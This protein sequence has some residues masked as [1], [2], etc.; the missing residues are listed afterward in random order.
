[1]KMKKMITIPLMLAILLSLLSWSALAPAAAAAGPGGVKDF[2]AVWV[3]TVVNLDYPSKS[4]LT[5][6]QLRSEADKILDAAKDLNMTAV[7]LQVRPT[8]DAI[9]PS[10]IFPWSRFLSGSQ[11]VAPPENFDALKYYIDGAHARGMELHAWINPYRISMGSSGAPEHNTNG[12]A[13][14]NPARQHPEWVI[15]HTD[16]RMYYD[17]GIPE[18]RQLVIDGVMEI[19]ENY[20]VDGIHFDDYFYPGKVADSAAFARYPRGFKDIETWRRDNVDLLVKELSDKIKQAAPGVRFGI[21]PAGIWANKS[22]SA[23]GSDTRGNESYVA[24]YADTRKW[25]KLGWLDYIAP[26][27]YWNIGYSIADYAKLVPWWADV[28]K[29]T[30][31]DLYIGLPDYRVDPA[32]SSSSVWK[33]AD[34]IIRQIEFNMK[35]A[36]VTGEIHFR[37]GSLT[38]NTAL[39]SAVKAAY[40]DGKPSD[41]VFTS[42]GG[43]GGN[44]SANAINW[45]T[46]A[47]AAVEPFRTVAFRRP[48]GSITTS[49]DKYYVMGVSDPSL[50]LKI[51]GEEVANR[52]AAGF[53]AK[54]VTLKSG[55][56]TVTAT[57]GNNVT[58]ITITRSSGTSS[59]PKPVD[60][61]TLASM[62]PSA[63]QYRQSGDAMPVSCV[64]PIGATVTATLGGQTITLKAAATSKPDSK[65]YNTTFSGSFKL[66]AAGAG[67]INKLGRVSYKMTYSGKTV[68]GQSGA[69]TSVIGSGARVYIEVTSGSTWFYD[70]N[71]STGGPSGELYRGMKDYVVTTTGN[72]IKLSMGKWVYDDNVRLYTTDNGLMT[73][74]SNPAYTRGEKYDL[75]SIDSSAPV[76]LNITQT[77]A[78]LTIR[79][80]NS[81]GMPPLTLP[82]GT[83]FS[84]AAV[85]RSGNVTTY[86]LT[87]ASGQKLDGFSYEREAG[88][89]LKIYIKPKPKVDASAARPLSGITVVL[90]PGHGGSAT[91]TYGP[92][93]SAYL[94]KHM[95]LDISHELRK[96]LENIGAK[97]VMT[98]TDDSYVEL[99]DRV[100][101]SRTAK[102]DLF[103]SVH[104]NA[105]AENVDSINI[106]GHGCYYREANAKDFAT[107]LYD[108]INADLGRAKRGLRRENFYVNRSYF[109]PSV[110]LECGFATNPAEFEWMITQKGQQEL[111]QTVANSI[112]KYFAS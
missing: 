11:G 96:C 59:S 64:A 46:G 89:P 29:D 103:L 36:E 52:S 9:Y 72:W 3:S 1:M 25:V 74:L 110:L 49:Y 7:I 6:A 8:S 65:I 102:A 35:Y 16:G 112:L 2:R 85:S 76:T 50:P 47:Y 22:T 97:V 90:D 87:V 86:T 17:P 28:C 20:D 48:S 10:K 101:M 32:L 99:D 111:A 104:I 63:V 70:S 84:S 40:K 73:T 33:T 95:A 4:N 69:E 81:S 54:L 41:K 34:E 68:T 109:A 62:S 21:S 92:L 100:E 82:I 38:G 19:I 94:E 45:Q 43:T 79:I 30:G 23:F 83:I 39:Y 56:N 106:F 44:N 98:R 58:T 55:A 71:T 93:G 12:L 61:A 75:L 77:A 57:N 66:P 78:A 26:Q 91:G 5:A 31:V 80:Y 107:Q 42:T 24:S 15:K 51:N 108:D 37:V 60:S 67:V 88:G 14:M 53:F 27:V 18:V 105:M 13:V